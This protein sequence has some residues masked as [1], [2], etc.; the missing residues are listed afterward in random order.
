MKLKYSKY[1]QP[2]AIFIQW[3]EHL[4]FE[5][6]R[7]NKDPVRIRPSPRNAIDSNTL[8]KDSILRSQAYAYLITKSGT[9]ENHARIAFDSVHAIYNDTLIVD[10]TLD[11]ANAEFYGV[12]EIGRIDKARDNQHSGTKTNKRVAD[13]ILDKL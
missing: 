10:F 1:P 3:P 7:L 6:V 12:K 2:K 5:L 9:L 8:S 4:R 13:F 11:S